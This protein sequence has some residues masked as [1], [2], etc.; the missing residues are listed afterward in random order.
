MKMKQHN[1]MDESYTC[2]TKE[3]EKDRSGYILYEYAH[4]CQKKTI[5]SLLVRH[6]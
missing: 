6:S 5:L 2:K 1:N 3:K 4:K